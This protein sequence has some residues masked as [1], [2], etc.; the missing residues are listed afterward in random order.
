MTSSMTSHATI[1]NSTFAEP[2]SAESTMSS[3]D[4]PSDFTENVFEYMK[5]NKQTT[6]K[7]PRLVKPKVKPKPKRQFK[8]EE[9]GIIIGSPSEF[10]DDFTDYTINKRAVSSPAKSENSDLDGPSDFT[11]NIVDY[12]KGNKPYS[13]TARDSPGFVGTR[14]AMS[15]SPVHKKSID[16]KTVSSP[17]RSENPNLDGPSDFT[18]NIVGYMKGD[19]A[20]SPPPKNSPGIVGAGKV[21][22]SPPMR[23]DAG[24]NGSKPTSQ[25]NFPPSSQL[26]DTVPNS[27]PKMNQNLVINGPSNFTASLAA[28]IN[29]SSARCASVHTT[30]S[31]K[32]TIRP[33]SSPAR[34]ENFEV[35]GRADF[36]PKL[37]D[38]IDEKTKESATVP[39]SPVSK[40]NTNMTKQATYV[41]EIPTLN[42]PSAKA[43]SSSKHDNSGVRDPSTSARNLSNFTQKK[44]QQP[45]AAARSIINQKDNTTTTKMATP[46]VKTTPLSMPPTRAMSSSKHDD[47][48][49]EGP[50]DFTENLVDSLNG[51]STK[52]ALTRKSDSKKTD[53]HSPT[54]KTAAIGKPAPRPAHVAKKDGL[55]I[56]GPSDFTENLV[57]YMKG[58]KTYSPHAKTS[59]SATIAVA[60]NSTETIGKASSSGQED[61]LRAEI[62]RLQALLLQKDKTITGLQDSLAVAENKSADLQCELE[63]KYTTIDKLQ[64]SL[65]QCNQQ[66]QGLGFE[67]H[68]MKMEVDELQGNLNVSTNSGPEG[69]KQ[70]ADGHAKDVIINTVQPK[71]QVINRLHHNNENQLGQIADLRSEI[72]DKDLLL[73]ET[74]E[75]VHKPQSETDCELLKDALSEH[76][77]ALNTQHYISDNLAAEKKE[78]EGT[79]ASLQ[80]RQ[81]EMEEKQEKREEEWQARVELLL[82]EV[83]RRGA[84]CMELWGQ[85]EHPGER[86]EKGRQKYTYKYTRK[87]TKRA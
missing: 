65:K 3:I 46:A 83:E 60:T 82:Q 48:N 40:N 87:G 78:L 26:A 11:A 72:A 18:A 54:T 1:G 42:M 70:D 57:D 5:S 71:D 13:P 35:D 8:Q 14:A 80:K 37:A 76:A 19:K 74:V 53:K 56:E 15:S 47:F 59:S 28:F 84:A 44:S 51:T 4:G 27:A 30:S 77:N 66:C 34:V 21:K 32:V 16:N 55:V 25:P 63:Q 50:T 2:R 10:S 81:A 64:T 79:V 9:S 41:E 68:Q 62:A 7:K 85:L 33:M 20:D 75:V 38:Y 39:T 45:V 23:E 29:E 86:D 17:A 12:M 31:P 61:E 67:L 24:S 36:A 58:T 52:P 22:A 73:I 49:I 43:R 6:A 69:G